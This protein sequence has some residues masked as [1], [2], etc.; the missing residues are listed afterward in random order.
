MSENK[1]EHVVMAF[2]ASK[3]A[4]ELAVDALKDWDHADKEIKLGAIGLIYKEDGEIKTQS[5]RST[6]R[7][8]AVGAVLGV[9]AAALGPVGLI[10]GA[11]SGGALGGVIGAFFKRSVDLDEAALQEIDAHLDAGKFGVVV[12]VDEFE[13]A[14]TAAQLAN[15]GGAV[16]QFTVPSDALHEVAQVIPQEY[17]QG[18]EAR[19]ND[20]DSAQIVA[21]SSVLP[22]T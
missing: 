18:F 7:G 9:F 22:L 20:L 5:P 1:N 2:F 15:S 17:N 16:Q 6:G 8:L 12:A 21:S 19:R 4:A 13:M 14:P 11:V 10:A 3:E